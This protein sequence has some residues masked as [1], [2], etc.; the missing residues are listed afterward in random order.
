MLSVSAD[1][2]FSLAIGIFSACLFLVIFI[3]HPALSVFI[4]ILIYAAVCA[5]ILLYSYNTIRSARGICENIVK[6]AETMDKKEFEKACREAEEAGEIFGGFYFGENYLFSPFGV[7]I[8][9]DSI[10]AVRAEFVYAVKKWEIKP[11]D[12]ITVCFTLSDGEKVSAV[13]RGSRA[14]KAFNS[15]FDEFSNLIRAGCGDV[16]LDN[17]YL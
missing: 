17:V 2:I 15:G 9:R 1:G 6:A 16:S 14:V 5:P 8:R 13:I 11:F 12:R 4:A 3:F 10:R 7:I